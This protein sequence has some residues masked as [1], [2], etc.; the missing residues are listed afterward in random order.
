[1]INHLGD[2]VMKLLQVQYFKKANHDNY[3]YLAYDQSTVRF[4]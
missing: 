1:V 2:E 4:E 3:P